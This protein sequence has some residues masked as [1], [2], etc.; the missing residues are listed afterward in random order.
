MRLI[1]RQRAALLAALMTLL[2]AVYMI[3][4]SARIEATDTLFMFD[5]VSSLVDFGDLRLDLT[6]GERYLNVYNTV[7]DDLPLL[8]VDA[9]PVQIVLAAPLYWLAS[10]VPGVGAVHTVWLFNVL[11]SALVAGVFALYGVQLGYSDRAAFGGALL[12]GLAT[13]IW[14]YSKSFFQEPLTLLSILLTALLLERWRAR[15]Y[16]AWGW[17]LAAGGVLVLSV[18]SRRSAIIALSVY[19]VIAAPGVERVFRAWWRRVAFWVLVAAVGGGLYWF[20][21]SPEW[22]VSIPGWQRSFNSAI[23]GYLFSIGGSIW[24]TSPVLILAVPGMLWLTWKNRMRYVVAGL[25]LLLVYAVA[26]AYL[27]GGDWFGGLSWP[28][29]FL[30]PVVP[31]LMLGVLPVLE[32]LLHPRRGWRWPVVIASTA[33]VTG[34]SLWIQFN[35]VSYWWGGYPELLPPVAN[36]IIEWDGGLNQI[37]YLRWVL[38]PQLWGQRPFDFAWVRA[39]QPWLAAMFAG[40]AVL[41]VVGWGLAGRKRWQWGVIVGLPVLWLGAVSVHLTTI[42]QD[43]L[44]LAFSDGLRET[45]QVIEHEL[46]D[47]DLL[48]IGQ[49]GYERYFL[50]YPLD[51]VRA[52]SLPPHP[53]EQPSPDQP[54]AVTSANPARLLRPTATQFIETVTGQQ[55]RL[56]VL[57]DATPFIPWAVRPLEQYMSMHYYPLRSFDLTDED[58]LPIRLV[59]YVTADENAA[60]LTLRGA[61]SAS[62]LRYGESIALA[63]YTLPTGNTYAPGDA[64]PISLLW[65]ADAPPSASYVVALH[66]AQPGVGVFA[67]AEDSPPQAGFAPTDGWTSEQVTWDNRALRLPADIPP[68][69]YVLWLGLYGFDD[70]GQPQ[71]LPVTGG[72]TAEDGT[73]GVLPVTITVQPRE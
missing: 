46:G 16:R 1:T 57:Y 11:V 32:F 59:E 31:F 15:G 43:D 62:G 8:P 23:R 69:E 64:L 10:V 53:G 34:Y 61:A 12:L 28:P 50:N 63:G 27:V 65:T 51:G 4:Y 39:G 56:W 58:G 7:P 9:E 67:S 13:I 44:Y 24:G 26:F 19:V 48:V 40:V 29:R 72:T 36:G 45:A 18:L 35:A 54:P 70:S 66:L 49:L 25:T 33:L 20:T 30:Y 14:P 42:Y 5:A 38:L 21:A 52:V 55:E 41:A 60:P 6:A 22:G 47:D 68:G 37:R 71:L 3:T 17:A 73:L 2:A